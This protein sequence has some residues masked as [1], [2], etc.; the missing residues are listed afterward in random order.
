MSQ[1]YIKEKVLKNHSKA[2]TLEAM[3]ISLEQMEK[4][5]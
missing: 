1:D 2:K 3:K 4:S 5:L